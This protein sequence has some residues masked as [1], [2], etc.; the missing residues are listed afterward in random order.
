[1]FT[2]LPLPNKQGSPKW[3]TK[4]VN[5]PVKHYQNIYDIIA[6]TQSTIFVISGW[7]IQREKHFVVVNSV[8]TLIV[9]GRRNASHDNRV[10]ASAQ[11]NDIR[12]RGN[13]TYCLPLS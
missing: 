2:V 7:N 12:N 6:K 4:R 11:R 9:Q 3:L 8:F 13:P 1:M 10:W 5:T